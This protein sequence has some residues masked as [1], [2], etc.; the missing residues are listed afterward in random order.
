MTINFSRLVLSPCMTTFA[1]TVTIDP[2]SSQPGAPPYQARGIFSSDPFDIQALDGN[3][4]SDQKTELGIRL[5]EWA[6]MP[7][8]CPRDKITI[9]TEGKSIVWFVS[10]N[11]EDGQGGMTLSLRYVTPNKTMTDTRDAD[12]T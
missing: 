2:V 11:D 1:R 8:P 10:D 12:I 7:S 6:G 3:I 4:I 9:T 5:A